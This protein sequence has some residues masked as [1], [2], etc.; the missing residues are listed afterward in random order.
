M[1]K[2]R[3]WRGDRS[4]EYLNENHM[5]L[6]YFLKSMIGNKCMLSL[7]N[8][9]IL[10]WVKSKCQYR[11]GWYIIS[12][13]NWRDRNIH[14]NL[15]ERWSFIQMSIYI[16]R[17][18]NSIQFY[19]VAICNLWPILVRIFFFLLGEIGYNFFYDFIIS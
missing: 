1:C 13:L 15:I 8:C 19:C 2:L 12:I 4:L 10:L 18:G 9:S 16:L 14:P 11:P 7:T 17:G 5:Y 3:L 6:Y